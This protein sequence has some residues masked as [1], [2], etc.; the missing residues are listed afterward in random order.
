M[1][2]SFTS[3]HFL[4]TG[5]IRTLMNAEAEEKRRSRFY[6]LHIRLV[7]NCALL[8][9]SKVMISWWTFS[10]RCCSCCWSCCVSS[11][12][13]ELD[14]TGLANW[15]GMEKR[16]QREQWGPRA[17]LNNSER[18]TAGKK[19]TRKHLHRDRD[20]VRPVQSSPV[21]LSEQLENFF[22]L[23]FDNFIFICCKYIWTKGKYWTS[24]KLPNKVSITTKKKQWSCLLLLMKWRYFIVP[25]LPFRTCNWQI[26]WT[27]H[28]S[29]WHC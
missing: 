25:N 21:Q 22:V 6:Y 20:D 1:A 17:K 7:S 29:P 23:K 24:S 3:L 8:E 9:L 13:A 4:A 16:K 26:V 5:T 28:K 15:T 2:F 18:S 27:C 10:R 11:H 12:F 19:E 14:W